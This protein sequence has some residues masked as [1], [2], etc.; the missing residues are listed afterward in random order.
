M[1]IYIMAV[2]VLISIYYKK[3]PS[4]IE[5]PISGSVLHTIDLYGWQDMDP[6]NACTISDIQSISKIYEGLYTYDPFKHP[7]EIIPNLA[8]DM[9]TISSDELTYTIKIKKGVF[10]QNDPCFPNG[11]GRELQASDFVFT[12]KRMV[13][14]SNTAPYS[15]LLNG[16]IK[17]LNEWKQSAVL[18]YGQE[19]K[20]LQALDPYTLQITLTAP[21]PNIVYILT[22]WPTFAVA[23]EAVQY[24]GA[25]FPNHPVGTGP[26]M[27]EGCFNRQAKQFTF[28]KNPTFRTEYFPSKVAPPYQ[29]MLAYAGQ[30]L[31]LVDKIITTVITGDQARWLNMQNKKNDIL[32]IEKTTFHLS[33][34]EHE[35]LLPTLE[36]K[37]LVLQKVDIDTIEYIGF[38]HSNELF[39]KNIALRQAMAMAFDKEM[40]N[41]L[42]YHNQAEVAHALISPK[43]LKGYMV[44]HPYDYNLKC[45]KAYLAEAGYPN[46]KGLPMITLDVIEET[47]DVQKATFFA[48][49]MAKIGIKIK[50]VSN[51]ARKFRKRMAA[52]ATML[53]IYSWLA[54][55]PEPA[56][57]LQVLRNKHLAN[58]EYQNDE[59]NKLFDEATAIRDKDKRYGTYASL[60][61]IAAEQV[62]MIYAVHYPLQILHYKWVKNVK[63]SEFGILLERYIAIDQ[64]DILK[65]GL[66]S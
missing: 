45:A 30:K 32:C 31:P 13:D 17:G 42:F 37:G 8:E 7:A 20:G 61:Q 40:Y 47:N 46:G 55:Y 2:I 44:S 1:L 62:P 22:M 14:P 23:Q 19:V 66:D 43:G 53:H 9:P 60:N 57:L 10:F 41:Q 39:G 33:M 29:H 50:V 25:D 21:F 59:F 5:T 15:S 65:M 51:V 27:L 18:D 56:S 11:T 6:L 28:I 52:N 64:T 24:Y 12:I 38:N 58:L 4:N 54:D 26:F 34:V 35:K 49:C 16:K 36:Q 48:Q 3:Y 63:Y